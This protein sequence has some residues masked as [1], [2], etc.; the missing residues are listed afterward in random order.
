MTHFLTYLVIVEILEDAADLVVRVLLMLL[1]EWLWYFHDIQI[2]WW[3]L[4]EQLQQ[5]AT[6]A[7]NQDAMHSIQEFESDQKW[8]ITYLY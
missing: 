1:V 7:C 2:T 4:L 8:K 5:I 6:S 3:V